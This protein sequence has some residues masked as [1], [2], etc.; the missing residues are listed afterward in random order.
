M[1]HDSLTRYLQRVEN[2]VKN[3]EGA[4]VE[5]YEEELLS[6]DRINLRIRIRFKSGDLLE[7]NE[8]VIS[9]HGE[10]NHLNYR[11]HFQDKKNKLIFRYDNAPH[12]P[13]VDSFPHHKHLQKEVIPSKQADLV[14]VIEEV[15]DKLKKSRT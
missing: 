2:A 10:I 7:I 11:Y 12:V 15:K 9:E 3:I 8:A 4:H 1:L 13:N 14:E 5:R 6:E